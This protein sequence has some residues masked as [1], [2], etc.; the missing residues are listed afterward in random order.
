MPKKISRK[1]IFFSQSIEKP[2]F[3]DKTKN[4]WDDRSNFEKVAGAYDMIDIDFGD[5][6]DEEEKVKD[7]EILCDLEFFFCRSLHLRQ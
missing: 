1:S 7:L 5:V 3:R 2:R 6:Q 4:D